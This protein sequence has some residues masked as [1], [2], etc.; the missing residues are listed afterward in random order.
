M[1]PFFPKRHAS[2]IAVALA[3]KMA[4]IAWAMMK[5]GEA[6]RQQPVADAVSA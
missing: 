2:E 6:Y 1:V 3:N 5:S 4:R